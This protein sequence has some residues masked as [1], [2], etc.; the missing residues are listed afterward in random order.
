MMA[1]RNRNIFLIVILLAVFSAGSAIGL[2]DSLE[3][4]QYE[5]YTVKILFG[6]HKCSCLEGQE[7]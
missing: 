5:N 7:L 4:Q 6:L 3:L 2:A 1:H